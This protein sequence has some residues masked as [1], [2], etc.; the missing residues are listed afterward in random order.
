MRLQDLYDALRAEFETDREPDVE[1]VRALLRSGADPN[2]E[3]ARNQ[4]CQQVPIHYAAQHNHLQAAEVLLNE[5]AA[6]PNLATDARNT[7]LHLAA[8]QGHE[9]M[10]ALL[11]RNKA[12]VTATTLSYWTALHWA[13][14]RGQRKVVELLLQAGAP[15]DAAT[16]LVETPLH[17]ACANGHEETAVRLLNAGANLRTH[18][19]GGM[20]P[21]DLAMRAGHTGLANTLFELQGSD[22]KP[23]MVVPRPVAGRDGALSPERAGRLSPTRS[24]K[25]GSSG[26]LS[27]ERMGMGRLS[28]APMIHGGASFSTPGWT[29]TAGEAAMEAEVGAAEAALERRDPAKAFLACHAMLEETRMSELLRKRLH[30]VLLAS[31]QFMIE[32]RAAGKWHEAVLITKMEGDLAAAQD[33]KA[34]LEDSLHHR[35]EEIME[36][37]AK[38]KLIGSGPD[39]A[40]REK[41]A[42]LE[43][44]LSKVQEELEQSTADAAEAVQAAEAAK[45]EAAKE[46]EDLA[47]KLQAAEA[48][49]AASASEVGGLKQTITEQAGEISRWKQ[50]LAGARTR[51]QELSEFYWTKS[52]NSAIKKQLKDMGDDA[53]RWTKPQ[54]IE[55]V[56]APDIALLADE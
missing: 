25:L 1:T 44:N 5:G 30:S 20:L 22:W 29:P 4:F 56:V 24:D 6:D 37:Q 15:V 27:P 21:Y 50:K 18:T 35:E 42:N 9:H 10:T 39:E 34:S 8:E 17:L 16:E 55:R 48:T 41:I 47:A 31:G 33:S 3:L 49:A 19:G 51:M 38:L 7:A 40:T 26:R 52:G 43:S 14:C 46:K 45:V 32:Q 12:D 23:G 54:Q 11:L 53:S 28:P 13:A 36:L 2:N